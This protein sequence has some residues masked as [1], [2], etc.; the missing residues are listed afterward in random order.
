MKTFKDNAGRSWTV[1]VTV[2]AVKRVRSLVGINLLDAIDGNL[3]ERLVGDPVLLCDVLFALCRPEA[4][5]LGVSDEAF[6]QAMAGDALEHA[7]SALLEELVD[8]FPNPKRRLL[9]KAL[10]K[11]RSV[12]AR[13]VQV[14]ERRLESPE[15]EAQI[16]TALAGLGSSSGNWPGSLA[17]PPDL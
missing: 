3:I 11:L 1:S 2:D 16:E 17:S 4:D 12:E 9:A 5:R 14:A 7:T 6:G 15:L 13:A 10:G 8:F